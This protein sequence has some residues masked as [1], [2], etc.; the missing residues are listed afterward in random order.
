M[1]FSGDDG[2]KHPPLAAQTVGPSQQFHADSAVPSSA[3]FSNF[4]VPGAGDP[5]GMIFPSLSPSLYVM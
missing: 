1:S 5:S 3:Y 4:P 2:L